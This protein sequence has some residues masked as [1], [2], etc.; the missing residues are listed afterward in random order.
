MFPYSKKT[1]VENWYEDRLQPAQPYELNPD[2]KIV[3]S[4]TDKQRIGSREG[5]VDQL[6]DVDGP[7]EA[8]REHHP[9]PEAGDL[10]GHP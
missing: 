3:R 4:H 10:R 8:P 7:A 6:P 2:Q 5:G 1:L 9:T